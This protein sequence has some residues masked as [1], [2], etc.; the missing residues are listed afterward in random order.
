VDK[1]AGKRFLVGAEF[2]GAAEGDAAA[3]GG[4]PAI[5]ASVHYW[6]TDIR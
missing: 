1:F 6:D 2:L 4:D 3:F 5:V